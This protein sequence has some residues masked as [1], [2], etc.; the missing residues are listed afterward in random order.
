M[1]QKANSLPPSLIFILSFL[2]LFTVQSAKLSLTILICQ[3]VYLQSFDFPA[4]VIE[5]YS[6]C[7]LEKH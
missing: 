6:L 1:G 4:C 3:T 7:S 2:N 5:I